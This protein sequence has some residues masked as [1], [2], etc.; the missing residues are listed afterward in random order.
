GVKVGVTTD[1]AVEEGQ[2][3]GVA[4]GAG[5]IADAAVEESQCPGVK[6]AQGDRVS[7]ASEGQAVECQYPRDLHVHHVK[8]AGT[9]SGDHR[10]VGSSP[11]HDN[12]TRNQR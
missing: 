3:P 7:S 6:D 4:N 9:G 10:A 11:A 12:G 2:C 5:G 8:L 1:A